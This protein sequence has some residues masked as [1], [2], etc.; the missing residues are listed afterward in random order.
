MSVDFQE[1]FILLQDSYFYKEVEEFICPITQTLIQKCVETSDGHKYEYYSIK[2]WLEDHD[3]SPLTN[4]K[5]KN[6]N[7]KYIRRYENIF[8]CN[9]CKCYMEIP[10]NICKYCEYSEYYRNYMSSLSM[11]DQI[12]KSLEQ[13]IVKCFN[14]IGLYHLLIENN[15]ILSIEQAQKLIKR[16]NDLGKYNYL[17]YHAIYSRVVERWKLDEKL[18]NIASCYYETKIKINEI[19]KLKTVCYSELFNY[20]KS[21]KN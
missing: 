17:W 9:N 8:Q 18:D 4:L 10:L 13:S 1:E 15:F 11:N 7:L 14:P 5:L 16:T 2:E 19:D 20:E 6:K 21:K 3:T 12:Y